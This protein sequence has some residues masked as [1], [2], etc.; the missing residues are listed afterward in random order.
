VAEEVVEASMPRIKRLIAEAVDEATRRL[1]AED[2]ERHQAR[3]LEL[4][5]RNQQALK[6]VRECQINEL[7]EFRDEMKTEFVE[8]MLVVK[9]EL[10]DLIN[11]KFSLATHQGGS[12]PRPPEL[13]SG[14]LPPGEPSPA[15]RVEFPGEGPN[16]WRGAFRAVG[17]RAGPQPPLGP[18]PRI[19]TGP[20]PQAPMGPPNVQGST[21]KAWREEWAG[22]SDPPGLVWDSRRPFNS[23]QRSISGGTSSSHYKCGSSKLKNF[24]GGSEEYVDWKQS[25]LRQVAREDNADPR[26]DGQ[27][28][29]D[30]LEGQARSFVSHLYKPLNADTYRSILAQ[31]DRLYFVFVFVFS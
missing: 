26:D 31:L 28:L 11:S 1:R 13:P 12:V 10:T 8:L 27:F 24:S 18:P 4:K 9:T 7:K 2:D 22:I 14:P 23:V 25:L 21:L 30:H 16:D 5:K 15:H 17:G 29:Y 6:E 20:P 3:M 19:P